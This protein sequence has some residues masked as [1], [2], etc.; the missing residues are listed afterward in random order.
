MCFILP[1]SPKFPL[2]S[3]HGLAPGKL[4]PHWNAWSAPWDNRDNIP[5]PQ[6]ELT[7]RTEPHMTPAAEIFSGRSGKAKDA[8]WKSW[9]Q[10]FLASACR[11]ESVWWAGDLSAPKMGLKSHPRPAQHHQCHGVAFSIQY[12]LLHLDLFNAKKSHKTSVYWQKGPMPEHFSLLQCKPVG[13]TK[14]EP[15]HVSASLYSMTKRSA[16]TELEHATQHV[17]WRRCD[18][19]QE[20]AV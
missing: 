2:E 9:K 3:R 20:T 4:R 5:K 6:N 1:G 17:W 15:Q 16:N 18:I 13:C 14:A 11:L 8:S 19:I 10:F 7:H 12:R